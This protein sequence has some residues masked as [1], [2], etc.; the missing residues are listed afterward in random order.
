MG[1]NLSSESRQLALLTKPVINKDGVV[2]DKGGEKNPLLLYDQETLN[3]VKGQFKRG[4][5]RAEF[6]DWNE[7]SFPVV[8]PVKIQIED[9]NG[10]EITLQ[11]YCY[12]ASKETEYKGIIFYVHGFTE[13]IERQ[14]HFAKEFSDLGFDFYAMDSRGHG[15]SGGQDMLVV[16]VEE[17]ADDHLMFHKE[18]I[19][20]HTVDGV[21]PP[22]FLLAT[23][24]GAMQMSNAMLRDAHMTGP[25][26]ASI[27]N[28]V[29]FLCPFWCIPNYSQIQSYW[30]ML[31]MQLQLYGNTSLCTEMQVDPDK[32]SDHQVHW[33]FDKNN[34]I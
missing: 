33:A 26:D 34:R 8:N 9:W 6:L 13:Y 7:Y 30:W 5:K 28:A 22:T 24:F 2:T 15:K 25:E 17:V 3:F 18:I 14:V 20:Q 4:Q 21:K 1:A 16:S 10:E 29:T 11:N 23:C 27:Y 12:P 32:L 19:E 31:N